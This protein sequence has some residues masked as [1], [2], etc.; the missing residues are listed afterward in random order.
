M[1]INGVDKRCPCGVSLPIGAGHSRIYCRDC[2][3]KR[4]YDKGKRMYKNRRIRGI[5]RKICT[6]LKHNTHIY[7][8]ITK[9]RE[10]RKIMVSWES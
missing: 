2:K 10:E 5:F 4:N 9:H 8:A 1:K 6:S 7:L 3:Y